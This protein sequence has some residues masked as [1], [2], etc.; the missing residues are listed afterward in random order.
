FIRA[1]P[2]ES[3]IIYCA[4]RKT[5][6]TLATK[7]TS[8][9]IRAKAYHAGLD[10]KERA[11]N[12]EAF[13]RDDARVI[14]ATIAFGMGINKPNVR[15]VVH[16]DMPKNIEGYYQETGRAGRDGLPSECLL[17]FSPNDVAKLM[18]FIEDMSDPAEQQHAKKQLNQMVNYGE[19]STCRRSALLKY[20]AETYPEADCAS[21]DNCLAP[22]P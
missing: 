13:L 16:F 19:C 22:R 9:G 3:G 10:P 20:F 12:Q 18:R 11:K 17:L 4:S 7:L 8:E 1:R 14:A 15:F 2:N 21:C 6:D 5:A